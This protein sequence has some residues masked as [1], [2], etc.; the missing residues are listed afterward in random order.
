MPSVRTAKRNLKKPFIATFPPSFYGNAGK[1]QSVAILNPRRY[2]ESAGARPARRGERRC[3]RPF[4]PWPFSSFSSPPPQPARAS[5]RPSSPASS[6]RPIRPG[7]PPRSTATWPGPGRRPPRPAG[8]SASSPPTPDISIPDG[9]PPPPTRASAAGRSIRWS[10]SDPPTASRSRAFRSGPTAGSRPLSEP[11]G[12][13]RAWPRRW[14]RRPVPGSGPRPSP[15]SIRSRSKCRSSSGPCPGR[16]SS[17]SSWAPKR[18]RPSG[19]WR[20]PWPRPAAA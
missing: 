19:R 1:S 13:T 5:G 14:P 4:P 9:P 2:S 7:W 18:D 6:I 17:P 10:S 20:R 3:R 16:P 11:P 12:S 8:S 15:K